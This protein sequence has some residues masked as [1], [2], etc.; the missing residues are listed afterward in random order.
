[1][2]VQLLHLSDL[3]FGGLA[4]VD[5]IEGLE[6]MLPDLRPDAVVLT[7]DLSQRARHG[8][9][10]RARALVQ[11]AA[12]TAPVLV[13]P[14]NHDVAWWIRPLIPFAK[15]PLH[16]KYARYFGADLAPT[17]ALPGAIIASALTSH[18]VAWGSLTL[19]VRDLAVKGHLPNP[20][21]ARVRGLFEAAPREQARGLAG[22]PNGRRGDSASRTG[23]AR[24]RQAQRRIVASGAQVVL[25]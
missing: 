21:V 22:R 2:T 5:Q 25:C 19:R 18:G 6:Q 24:W 4:D 12:R 8:E 10:Q 17:L 23:L 14:G 13:I 1:M 7:G 9:F 20:E 16:A 3:H 11:T 15:Q